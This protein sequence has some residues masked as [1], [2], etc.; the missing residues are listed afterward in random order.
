MPALL[1]HQPARGIG[2]SLLTNRNRLADPR[3][4]LSHP[5]VRDHPFRPATRCATLRTLFAGARGGRKAATR[6]ADAVESC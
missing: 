3:R 6:C 5:G 4:S 2:G 1:S